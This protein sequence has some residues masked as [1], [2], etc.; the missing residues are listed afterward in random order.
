[1]FLFGFTSTTLDK[2]LAES[3]IKYDEDCSYSPCLIQ[4]DWKSS[5]GYF[6]LDIG[7][8]PNE[9]EV[10]ISDGLAFKVLSIE[11]IRNERG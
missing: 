11:Q 9:K 5:Y 3:Y 7:A 4:I 2:K 10:I 8:F 1:M 6:L